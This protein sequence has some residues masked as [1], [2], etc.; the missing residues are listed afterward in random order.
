VAEQRKNVVFILWGKQAQKKIKLIDKSR[1]LVLQSPHPS[2]LSASRG[3]FGNKH[4]SQTNTF[5][6]K[7]GSAPIDWQI[8]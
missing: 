1:H 8:S 4:F 5:L 6:V 7:H 3:F 2:G